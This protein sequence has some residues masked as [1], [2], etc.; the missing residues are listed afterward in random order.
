MPLF[1]DAGLVLYGPAESRAKDSVGFAVAGGLHRGDNLE[2]T[3]EWNYGLR[4][5]PGFLLQPDV[6][7]IVHP[8]GDSS[9]ANALA[10][11]LNVVVNL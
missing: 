4:L 3:L 2:L 9:I 10:L 6:Q 7:Y 11:G 8:A 5:L 1:F